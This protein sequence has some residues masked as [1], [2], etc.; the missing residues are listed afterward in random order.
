M[1]LRQTIKTKHCGAKHKCRKLRRKESR[2]IER[3]SQIEIERTDV[4]FY[5]LLDF[6]EEGMFDLGES[7]KGKI[8]ALHAEDEG[9]IPSLST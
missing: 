2:K 8:S 3:D 9:S 5:E 1:S 6:V 4:S 7:S